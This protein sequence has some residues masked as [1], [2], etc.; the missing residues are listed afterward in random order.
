MS[1]GGTGSGAV[2]EMNQKTGGWEAREE[3]G[4]RFQVRVAEG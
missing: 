3:A 2:C 1:R 4:V